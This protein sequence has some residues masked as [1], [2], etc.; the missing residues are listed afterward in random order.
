MWNA[1]V[2]PCNSFAKT[3]TWWL[4]MSV[5][6]A[7][8]VLA[9]VSL[10][11]FMIRRKASPQLGC[12]L[13]LLVLVKLF[14]PLEIAVPEQVVSWMPAFALRVESVPAAATQP[15]FDGERHEARGPV[16]AG[17]PVDAM[18]P[19]ARIAVASEASESPP[20]AVTPAPPRLSPLAWLMF[21]WA[22][23]VLA[24][25]ARLVYSQVRFHRVILRDALPMPEGPPS[26]DFARLV[27]QMG[28][29]R[30]LRI[31]ES[32]ALSSPVVWG[33]F[34]PTLILP[35]GISS[36][37]SARQLEWVLLHELAH[38]RRRDLTVRCFQC[39]A[40]IVHFANPA[41]WL[42]NR[43]INRLREY[44]C[45]DVASALS[46]GSHVESSEAFLGVMRYAASVQR[47]SAVNVDAAIGVFESMSRASCFERMKRLLDA[48]RRMSVRLG[49]G[50]ICLLLL[51][52]ALALPQI[53]AAS[54]P[55]AKEK[56]AGSEV[57]K[58]ATPAA[59]QGKGEEAAE[60][61]VYSPSVIIA[62]HV[63]LFEGKEIVTWPQIE[64]RLLK[65]LNPSR[66]RPS[67]YF[68]HGA[69][70]TT[71]YDAA[72]KEIWRLHST[73]KFLG[74]S[75][76]S[77]ALRTSWRYD[78]IRTADDL[79]T[80]KLPAVEG[81]VVDTKGKPIAGA[82]VVLVAPLPDAV[83]YKTYDM[84]LVKGRV[85]NPI[86]HVMAVSDKRGRFKLR[87][88]E[89]QDFTLLAFHPDGGIGY[90]GRD[91]IARD[92]HKI[93][94][95]AWGGLNVKFGKDEEGQ[96][97]SLSTR[98][99]ASGKLPEIAISEG[100]ER[101][102]DEPAAQPVRF[103]RV[104]PNRQATICRMFP[105][106][107]GSV[108]SLP[109]ASVNLMSGETREIDLGPL[110]KQQ[111]EFL[112]RMRKN[113]EEW[114]RKNVDAAMSQTGGSGKKPEATVRTVSQKTT[115]AV[116]PDG[117]GR[118]ELTVLGP[119]KKPVPRASVQ[120]RGD[121]L[122][123]KK[124]IRQGTF[125]KPG[126]YGVF[127][128]TDA[129]GVL[130][131]DVAGKPR[132]F[133]MCI[134]EPG[135]GAYW[136]E[137][138]A[139]RHPETIPS[140]FTAELEAGWPAGGVIVDDK[141]TPIA[142]AVVWPSFKFTKRPG[143][144]AELWNGRKVTSDAEGKWRF[145]SI[146][147]SLNEVW[148]EITH[149]EFKPNRRSLTRSEFGLAPGGQPTARIVMR[150]GLSVVGRVT[151]EK[152]KPIAGALLRTKFMN[153]VRE[154]RTDAEGNYRLVGCE[155]RMTKIVVSAK[156]RAMDRK[157]VEV[158][159]DMGP[160]NFKM[161]PGGKIRV[162]VLDANGKPAGRTRI[163]FQQWRGHIEYFEFEHINQ[164]SDANGVWQW[165]EAPLDEFVADICPRGGGMQLVERPLV[166]RKEE[167][168]FRTY[169]ELVVAGRVVDS[170]TRKPV[171]SFRVVPGIRSYS[172]PGAQS[173]ETH[174]S[175]ERGNSYQGK[176]GQYSVKFDREYLAHLVRIEA[177]GYQVAT[178]RDIKSD[179]GNVNVEFAL[180]RAKDVAATVLMPDGRPAAGAQIA[181][182]LPGSQISIT[183]G[184]FDGSTYSARLVA[185]DDGQF[186]F[187]SQNEA[188]QLIV[189]HPTGFAS[190]RT[191]EEE[192]P[193][194]I[195]LTAWARVEGTFRVG[196]KAVSGVSIT[197]NVRSGVE[198]YGN[199]VPHIF[200]HYRVTSGVDGR[201][202]F[203]RMFPG[204]GRVGR[205]IVLMVNQ[206]AA[207]AT[208]STRVP[209]SFI[210]GQTTRVELGGVG[211]PVVGKLVP[212]KGITGKVLWQ[213][214]M[215]DVDVDLPQGLA[216]EVRE[217]LR[218]A[219]P[220]IWATVTR[221]GSFRIDDMPPGVYVLSVRFSEHAAGTLS[222]YRFEVPT[223]DGKRSDHPFDLGT[224]ELK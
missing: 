88:P 222:N 176:D 224:L 62:R 117:G 54:D 81:T 23:I 65:R 184:E 156:G 213:F 30:P 57:E 40:T 49:I 128:R 112:E 163:F 193:D 4:G 38:V 29:V 10:L 179:E 97:V 155:P 51:T 106:E 115:P 32:E 135:Y 165:D 72:K 209:V 9:I 33:M 100:D 122:P 15:V 98:I 161:E 111:R 125:E 167:Y 150:R 146:P 42:A 116:L 159:S 58:K 86:E 190:L 48:K 94:L 134:D 71:N 41:V 133:S 217:S 132:R 101:T 188:F 139:E 21:A 60:D 192:I 27:R 84:T 99:D 70:E 46:R 114:H 148:A 207:E 12:L 39:L 96:S 76:G 147:A 136:A 182:G 144:N 95:L 11:W 152:G 186:R 181:I 28:I 219:N 35:A 214:A 153:D 92:D 103:K 130:V 1:I 175:W 67:F 131:F 141:G 126:P 215:I 77:L 160:V 25:F 168:V 199:D 74:H 109:G 138:N 2:E 143:D 36:S 44:A 5:L 7:A 73:Y 6:D 82:E 107:H 119:D 20:V 80:A 173:G 127:L 197:A 83:G 85:Y 113:S 205:E 220:H 110:S 123:A 145:D 216:D 201:F 174:V 154:A 166:A 170:K 18:A 87:A 17:P 203:E 171:N 31:V 102:E 158:A 26:V 183:N 194:K 19:S 61:E 198:A 93:T 218:A 43:M 212:P 3:W 172:N 120:V 91:A 177:D 34:R 196:A 47:R 68:T 208:S 64:A 140:R 178:S 8:I 56:A 221:D 75:E 53:R 69:F 50:S 164:Y 79:K 185:G 210:A 55:P 142:G 37:L 191:A 121:V 149:P 14:V 104:P 16:M 52:A 206:G 180:V 108:F 66:S 187:P 137:W 200:T 204:D 124:D 45:D 151:D 223:I 24:L 189:L 89:N 63:M 118:F 22:S 13:F 129:N 105:G 59:N 90:S 202:A 195:K 157:Q 169:P 78:Q 211:R 162:R